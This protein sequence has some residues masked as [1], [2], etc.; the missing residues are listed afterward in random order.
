MVRKH[1]QECHQGHQMGSNHHVL[2]AR[3][4]SG[5]DMRQTMIALYFHNV[6]LTCTVF[7]QENSISDL[8]FP[9][10]ALFHLLNENTTFWTPSLPLKMGKEEKQALTFLQA[11]ACQRWNDRVSLLCWIIY[12]TLCNCTV[13]MQMIRCQTLKDK[14]HYSVCYTRDVPSPLSN[15]H[16]KPNTPWKIDSSQ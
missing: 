3:T 11:A 5:Q 16:S 15:C 2:L 6:V 4:C 1:E 8:D 9:N 14:C 7:L 13:T 12:R 10:M